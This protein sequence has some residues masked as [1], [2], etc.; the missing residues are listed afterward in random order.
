MSEVFCYLL[1]VTVLAIAGT[2]GYK[3]GAARQL[4]SLLAIIVGILAVR[5]VEA[6]WEAVLRGALPFDREGAASEFVYGNIS[7]ST[8]FLGIYIIIFTPCLFLSNTLRL[9]PVEILG[10]ICGAGLAIVKATFWLSLFLNLW[11]SLRPY[12]KGVMHSAEAGDGNLIAA[13]MWV[14]PMLFGTPDTGD[15]HHAF[16]LEQARQFERARGIGKADS[17]EATDLYAP[18][19][20]N[21]KKIHRINRNKYAQSKRTTC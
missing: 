5:I 10:K 4:P 12:D 17:E 6:P 14:S 18:E 21:K 8:I 7:A 13:V 16:Q 15:L 11:M 20:V 3:K 19:F 1:I 9:L 2:R